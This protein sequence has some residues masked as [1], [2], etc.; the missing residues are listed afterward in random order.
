MALDYYKSFF[1][2]SRQQNAFICNYREHWFTVR[3]IG[4]QWF[5]LNSLLTGP[6]LVSN[7]FLS[8][9]LVQLETVRFKVEIQ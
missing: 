6:E 3:K 5:N 8:M 7:T 9:F 2:F 4:T 1:P